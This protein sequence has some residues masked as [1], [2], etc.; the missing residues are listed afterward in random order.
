MTTERRLNVG[1]RALADQ[2]FGAALD[3][4]RVR[5]V[6]REHWASAGATLIGRGQQI[7][8]RG[9]RIFVPGG[10][11]GMA[12]PDFCAQGPAMSALLAHELTHVW[13]YQMGHMTG[14]SYVLSFNWRYDYALEP[15]RDFLDYGFE[16]QASIVEDYVRLTFGMPARRATHPV[17]AGSL[18]AMMPFGAR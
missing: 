15:G 12:P 17:K 4:S 18:R 16:Q 1:E 6:G 10:K 8:V 11:T 2:V 5:I 7:V 14:A 9:D 13:Q 3:A